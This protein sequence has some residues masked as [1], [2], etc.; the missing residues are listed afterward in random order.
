MK[1]KRPALI[2]RELPVGRHCR[3]FDAQR[4]GVVEAEYAA[5]RHALA[6]MKIGWLG[7]DRDRGRPV[8]LSFGAVAA[9]AHGLVKLCA[10]FEVWC[11]FRR[12]RDVVGADY[13]P[14]QLARC[15]GDGF[16]RSLLL[17]HARKFSGL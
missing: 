11:G 1:R 3:A 16:G 17:H 4:Y 8:T 2:F 6:I 13:V 10:R 9:R 5:I 15:G 14:A 7:I 12:Y